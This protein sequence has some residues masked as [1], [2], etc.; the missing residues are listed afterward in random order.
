MTIQRE[1]QNLEKVQSRVMRF[2]KY[3]E[4]HHPG[5]YDDLTRKLACVVGTI[6]DALTFDEDKF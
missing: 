2:A 1:L 6:E 4:K 3:L 5:R